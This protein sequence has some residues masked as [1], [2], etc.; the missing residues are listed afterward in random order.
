MTLYDSL[1]LYDG[2]CMAWMESE[3]V[4]NHTVIPGIIARMARLLP[5]YA[6]G[7]Y[8]PASPTRR[9]IA[10]VLYNQIKEIELYDEHGK[11]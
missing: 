5:G 9:I 6:K 1:V 8:D 2:D 11:V 4:P 10:N 3:G 7:C